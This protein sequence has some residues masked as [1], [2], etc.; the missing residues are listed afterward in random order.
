MNKF[1]EIANAIADVF[2]GEYEDVALEY[3]LYHMSD[4]SGRIDFYILADH[5][6]YDVDL[7]TTSIRPFCEEANCLEVVM[8]DY[9]EDALGEPTPNSRSILFKDVDTL[10]VY[11]LA[12]H[13]IE[14]L[15]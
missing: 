14:N 11:W 1:A 13:I 3:G 7:H 15:V 10:P 6:D 8:F 5:T 9:D 2:D 12:R 4:D